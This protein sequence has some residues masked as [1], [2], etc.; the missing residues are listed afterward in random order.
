MSSTTGLSSRTRT[1]WFVVGL[2]CALA[3]LWLFAI[4]AFV[5]VGPATASLAFAA[6]VILSTVVAIGAALKL[7]HG[8]RRAS[9][10]LWIVL[11][12]AGAIGYFLWINLALL[13]LSTGD[14]PL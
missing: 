11:L 2:I 5:G 12:V 3:P 9:I 6:P 1:T 14:G 13:G 10:T 7:R 4:A 8:A